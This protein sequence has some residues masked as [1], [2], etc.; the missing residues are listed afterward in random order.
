MY[1]L[2][3]VVVTVVVLGEKQLQCISVASGIQ[4]S[5]LAHPEVAAQNVA[6]MTSALLFLLLKGP[7]QMLLLGLFGFPTRWFLKL[8]NKLVVCKKEHQTSRSNW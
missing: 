2:D 1:I 4:F 7:K 6:A 8:L 5:C 3:V